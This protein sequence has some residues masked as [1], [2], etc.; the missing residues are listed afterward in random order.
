MDQTCETERAEVGQALGEHQNKIT[1][2]NQSIIQKTPD[3]ETYES[4]IEMLDEV[5]EI[6]FDDLDQPQILVLLDRYSESIHKGEAKV[7]SVMRLTKLFS[8]SS[9]KVRKALVSLLAEI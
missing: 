5:F 3:H 8:H 6:G 2:V 4:E 1:A 9:I 7:E